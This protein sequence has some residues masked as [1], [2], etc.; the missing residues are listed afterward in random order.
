MHPA[1]REDVP[2]LTALTVMVT[3]LPGLAPAGLTDTFSVISALLMVRFAG[4]QLM[5]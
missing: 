4:V 3:G 5:V 2:A 1:T